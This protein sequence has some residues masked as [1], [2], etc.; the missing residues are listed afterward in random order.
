M[1]SKSELERIK[2]VDAGRVSGEYPTDVTALL[3]HIAEQEGEVE[4]LREA[5]GNLLIC[6]DK[7]RPKYEEAARAALGKE[8]QGTSS[9]RICVVCQRE[10]TDWVDPDGGP[11]RMCRECESRQG[12]PQ[13]DLRALLVEAHGLLVR[14][15]TEREWPNRSCAD[16][17][18]RI[19]AAVGTVGV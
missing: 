14:Y 9:V 18:T 13:P 6:F 17:L 2:R 8:A 15:K 16:L 4:R 19:E 12:L 10:V 7:D 5:L 1:L 11:G 3:R